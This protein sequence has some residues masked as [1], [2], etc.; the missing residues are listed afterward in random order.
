MD[1]QTGTT[2]WH[3][4]RRKNYV[5]LSVWISQI[6]FH[7]MSGICT[8]TH[9]MKHNFQLCQ[10]I[11]FR[12]LFTISCISFNKATVNVWCVGA[13]CVKKF[14][15]A[16]MN[17]Q[18]QHVYDFKRIFSMKNMREIICNAFCYVPTVHYEWKRNTHTNET[19]VLNHNK[20]LTV[21]SEFIYYKNAEKLGTLATSCHIVRCSFSMP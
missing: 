7:I 11:K 10:S 4:G 1:A 9:I 17:T 16:H 18:L 15:C 14:F 6:N 8:N 5:C 2:E 13:Q 20:K 12:M 21:Y 19:N 3:L